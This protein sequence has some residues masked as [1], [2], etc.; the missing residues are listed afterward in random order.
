MPTNKLPLLTR[1]QAAA[2]LNVAP[3]TLAK[4][5]CNKSHD[6][7]YIKL[8]SQVRYRVEEIEVFLDAN[9]CRPA[10]FDS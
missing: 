1:K 8:G 7:P 9:T 2:M 5:A 6:L 3:Q 10:K 4:W